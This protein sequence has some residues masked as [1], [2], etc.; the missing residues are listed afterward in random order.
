[1]R[2][3]ALPDKTGWVLVI[4]TRLAPFSKSVFAAAQADPAV[5]I[6]SSFRMQILPVTSPISA[7]IS[8]LL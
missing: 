6:M 2:S 4:N 3:N 1:M 8:A 5:S 7:V